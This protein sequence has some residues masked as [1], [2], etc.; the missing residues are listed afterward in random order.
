METRG[1]GFMIRAVLVP[2]HLLFFFGRGAALR[3]CGLVTVTGLSLDRGDRG[4]R[5]VPK[6]PYALLR[7]APL[8]GP[9]C[10]LRRDEAPGSKGLLAAARSGGPLC[11]SGLLGA[12]R[13]SA[14]LWT[15]T[16]TGLELMPF[17]CFCFA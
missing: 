9:P 15:G 2:A 4:D 5:G 6:G 8:K 3:P 1:T 10:G 17:L 11:Q 12:S 14:P 7:G 13:G 16:G